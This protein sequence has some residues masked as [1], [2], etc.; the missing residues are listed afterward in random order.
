MIVMKFGGSS[1]ASAELIRHAMNIAKE[2][3]HRK[4][5]VVVSALGK[6]TDALVAAGEAAL[7]GRDEVE[8]ICVYHQMIA[9]ELGLVM[10]L[11]P[12]AQRILLIGKKGS[13]QAT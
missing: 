4:P 6:T 11:L 12:P 3:L 10:R 5:F 9:T 7:Q 8:R 1:L 2:R 13:C